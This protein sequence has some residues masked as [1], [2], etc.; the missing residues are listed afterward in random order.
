MAQKVYEGWAIGRSSKD[1][2]ASILKL[3]DQKLP[4]N[5]DILRQIHH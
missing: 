4:V 3:L 5:F 1:S 2:L